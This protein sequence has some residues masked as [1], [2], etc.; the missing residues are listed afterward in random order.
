M[1]SELSIRVEGKE[2][3]REGRRERGKEGRYEAKWS[4]RDGVIKK[5]R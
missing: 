5:D 2:G 4:K 1:W 3:G